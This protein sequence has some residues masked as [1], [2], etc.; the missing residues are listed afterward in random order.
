VS[1]SM[2]PD[3]LR[4]RLRTILGSGKRTYGALRWSAT[5]VLGG[6]AQQER[7]RGTVP[8]HGERGRTPTE[9]LVLLAAYFRDSIGLPDRLRDT[10]GREPSAT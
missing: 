10:T 1:P 5:A 2:T 9:A 8:N 7:A 4:D 3:D 6:I